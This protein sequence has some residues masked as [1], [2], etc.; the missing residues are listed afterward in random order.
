MRSIAFYL[1]QFHPIPENNAWWGSGFTEWTNVAKARSLQRGHRQPD[2]PGEL[3]FYDLRVPE[4]RSQQA[5]LAREYGIDGF[6]YWH[7]W[8]AGKRLLERPFNDVLKSGQPDFPFCLAWANHSWTALWVG[9]PGRILI[10]QTY[11]GIEDE[12]AH[13]EC[14]LPAF[15]DPRY[16]RIHGKP[17]FFIFKMQDFPDPEGFSIRWNQWAREA[18]LPGLW[19]AEKRVSP[20][21]PTAGFSSSTYNIPDLMVRRLKQSSLEKL[22]DRIRQKYL[23]SPRVFS[24]KRLVENEMNRPLLKHE[25]PVVMPNWDNTPRSGKRGL[26]GLHPSPAIF[27]KWVTHAARQLADRHPEERIL[28]VRSWNEWAE[29]NYMEPS[30]FWGRAFLEAFKAGLEDAKDTQ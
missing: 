22:W 18:G 10:E 15:K 1:P 3:G 16:I 4:I 9:Q 27:R 6:C 14:L 8:Y 30:A 26:V 2:L 21:G 7:Y 11:P 24:F 12:R 25:W 17:L 29:G 23:G 28:C 5:A 13:F 19:L 20:E